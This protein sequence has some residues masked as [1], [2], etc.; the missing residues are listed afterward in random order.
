VSETNIIPD[1][2]KKDAIGKFAQVR[3]NNDAKSI[4]EFTRF[5]IQVVIDING[6]A[7]TALITLSAAMRDEALT[8]VYTFEVLIMLFL[9]G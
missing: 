8:T 3:S 7:A 5:M 6:F 4:F 1:K 2:L 9:F